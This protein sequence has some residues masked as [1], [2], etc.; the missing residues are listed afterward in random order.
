MSKKPTSQKIRKQG[1][2]FSK[3]L[4]KERQA[5]AFTQDQ[6]AKKA[7]VSLD[8]VR[9]MENGRIAAPGLFIA[10][11]LVEALNGDLSKWLKKIK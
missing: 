6:L 5:K 2:A 8:T 11:S 10:A 4:K 3:M 1:I 7:N 9:S